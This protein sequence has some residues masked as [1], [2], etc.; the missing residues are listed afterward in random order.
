MSIVETS[1]NDIITLTLY[2]IMIDSFI[3]ESK[4]GVLRINAVHYQ[5]HFQTSF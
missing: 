1:T 4:Y 3:I 5:T 2:Y